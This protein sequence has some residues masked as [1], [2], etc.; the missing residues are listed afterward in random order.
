MLD[1]SIKELR[2][3]LTTE[4]K[5]K[6]F[7][8]QN[9]EITE[10]YD[11]IKLTLI[12]NREPFDSSNYSKNWIVAYKGNILTFA[13]FVGL[14][15][16]RERE[17]LE[18]SIGISQFCLVLG[19]VALYHKECQ[20]FPCGTELFV[21]FIQNKPTITRDYTSFHDLF[22]IDA[23]KSDFAVLGQRL[24][25]VPSRRLDPKPFASML[26]LK[27]PTVLFDGPAKTFES[28]ENI[29]QK[30]SNFSSSLGGQAEGIVIKTES[31]DIYKV[32]A[33]D[34]YD[35]SVRRAKKQRF[36]ESEEDERFY[37]KRVYDQADELVKNVAHYTDFSEALADLSRVVYNLDDSE[38]YARN[39]KKTRIVRQDDLFLTTKIRLETMWDIQDSKSVGVFPMAG[40]PVHSGHW[41]M[42]ES[43][44]AENERVYLLVSAKD[45][46]D[47]QMTLRWV[48]TFG[49]WNRF[50]VK[51]LPT[52]VILRFCDSPVVE[53]AHLMQTFEQNEFDGKVRVYSGDDDQDRW[54][55]DVLQKTVPLMFRQ[56]RV[57]HVVYARKFVE[58]VSGTDMR[59]WIVDHSESDFCRHL[60]SCLTQDEKKEVW[61]TYSDAYENA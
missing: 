29:V 52:N 53:A 33:S 30:F 20:K 56:G 27:T 9:I 5:K 24:Y 36:V 31:G 58:C 60:P 1:L 23:A 2:K 25:S 34:Q 37:W 21:E 7:L 22:L 11:G 54:S 14:S 43:A 10:K 15:S 6:A 39:S 55:N 16:K 19:H 12:R 26:N 18:E 3:V 40:K 41:K 17:V 51:K 8:S 35:K 48:E 28:V 50:F 44:C 45:R 57:V 47:H 42:I 13:D 4:V 32:V 61:K 38:I 59:K 46:T 49:L